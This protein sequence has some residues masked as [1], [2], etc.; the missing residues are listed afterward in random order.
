[1]SE[2]W[3]REVHVRVTYVEQR[4]LTS[5]GSLC[6]AISLIMFVLSCTTAGWKGDIPSSKGGSEPGYLHKVSLSALNCS[7]LIWLSELSKDGLRSY[8]VSA[9]RV[10]VVPT[11][12]PRHFQLYKLP[13]TS[14]DAPD[15]SRRHCR[16]L[17]R[18]LKLIAATLVPS[19]HHTAG[20][21]TISK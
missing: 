4:V 13:S 8:G 7:G 1:M 16:T 17:P 15:P 5:V 19:S 3:K 18:S 14:S 6:F 11:L 9:K 21:A 10:G 2:E 12:L 20:R